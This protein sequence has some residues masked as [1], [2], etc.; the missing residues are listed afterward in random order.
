MDP[1]FKKQYN[2]HWW[3][4]LKEKQNQN[5]EYLSRITALK[6]RNKELISQKLEQESNKNLLENELVKT[7]KKIDEIKDLKLYNSSL[8]KLNAEMADKIKCLEKSLSEANV[9]QDYEN[10]W[11]FWNT[12]FIRIPRHTV[13]LNFLSRT[14]SSFH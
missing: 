11:A 5:S 9:Q 2:D 7:F 12:V 10:C 3:P 13:S 14:Q 8:V 1:E 4:K 6:L